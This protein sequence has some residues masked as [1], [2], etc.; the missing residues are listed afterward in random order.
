MLAVHG[1]GADPWLAAMADQVR[2][3]EE[4]EE[5]DVIPDDMADVEP[6]A[7]KKKV[8]HPCGLPT[9]QEE[10]NEL[11]KAEC[12]SG[13]FGCVYIG[14]REA[15]ALAYEDV[16]VLIDMIRTS[17]ART[18]P[19]NLSKHI[20][21]RYAYLR[22]EVN[23]SLL[24]GEKPLPEWTA[25]TIL[26]H[27]RNHNTDPEIQTWVR[28]A[29]LQELMQVALRASVEIDEDTGEKRVN[30]K[31]CKIYMDLVKAAES[32]YKSDPSK[33]IFFSGGAHIDMKSASQGLMAV[34]GKNIVDH[35]SKK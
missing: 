22:E 16:I 35:W 25:A 14:E 18:D 30:E 12:R 9:R 26:D 27:I 24:P 29:E 34:S 8:Y 23:A 21:E 11:G 5:E 28:L 7:K 32:L 31:Q 13:C 19:I 17:I 2:R 4:Q 33:K 1:N 3:Q 20:A 6:P 15:G 10:I